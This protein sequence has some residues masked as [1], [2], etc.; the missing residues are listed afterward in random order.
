[1]DAQLQHAPGSRQRYSNTDGPAWFAPDLQRQRHG[2][3][4]L[5]RLTSAAY[6]G[7]ENFTYTYDVVG[8]RLAM[9]T[10]NGSTSYEYDAAYSI[11]VELFG[12]GCYNG[13]VSRS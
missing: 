10:S 8:N 13:I 6:S 5:Y 9:R 3:D 4:D 11:N 2:Y 1:M 12:G 7:G